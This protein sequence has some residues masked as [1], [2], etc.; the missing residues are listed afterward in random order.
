M[1][2]YFILIFIWFF[3][4]LF[5]FKINFLKKLDVN[6]K[7][8]IYCF[9]IAFSLIIIIGCKSFSVGSD[10]QQYIYIYNHVYLTLKDIFSQQ[11]CGFYLYNYFL[12]FLKISDQWYLIFYAI[13][14]VSIH[15][16]FY[17]KYA[18]NLFL[19]F[20][21][22]LTLGAFTISMSGIR[23]T[24]ALSI[25]LLAFD[26]MEKKGFKNFFIYLCLILIASTI[27][28][29]ALYVIPFYLLKFV[30]FSKF[31]M[32]I[33]IVIL[34]VVLIFSQNIVLISSKF[35]LFEKYQ[36]YMNTSNTYVTNP[37]LIAIY[38]AILVFCLFLWKEDKWVNYSKIKEESNIKSIMG[39]G[40][41]VYVFFV[42]LGLY[43]IIIGRISF[44]F[45]TPLVIFLSNNISKIKNKN[46]RIIIL[47]FTI[48]L[49]GYM[50]FKSQSLHVI[51][52][53]FFWQNGF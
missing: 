17:K 40:I 2:P 39:W 15:T 28:I 10:T 4:Y 33:S 14:I 52:Y 19:T 38:F 24:L 37:L 16:W 7:R 43:N 45:Y 34:G 48:I 50:F 51:P 35:F 31:K 30:D 29:S 21:L 26:F 3:I 47:I 23:Q 53:Y 13:I 5:L 32:K 27:H 8:S 49:P 46:S 11:E 9:F 1:I 12:R 44:Y 36:K 18:D 20:Y 22:F 6:K 25:V 42:I 41:V